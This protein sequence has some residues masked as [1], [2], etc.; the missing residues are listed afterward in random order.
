MARIA[1]VQVVVDEPHRLHEGIDGGGA[2]KGP[3]ALFQ[4][5]VNTFPAGAIGEGAVYQ[6]YVFDSGRI[7]FGSCVVGNIGRGKED[8]GENGD[9]GKSS[10]SNSQRNLF[11]HVERL[12]LDSENYDWVEGGSF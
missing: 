9:G 4:V 5:F 3:A 12:F 11:F 2:Y 8:S 1:V 6:H 7:F 10:A